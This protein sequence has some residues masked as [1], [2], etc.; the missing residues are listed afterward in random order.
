MWWLISSVL[1]LRCWSRISGKPGDDTR[2][3]LRACLHRDLSPSTCF[4]ELWLET[5]RTALDSFGSP[6]ASPP[7][8]ILAAGTAWGEWSVRISSLRCGRRW[9]QPRAML[10]LPHNNPGDWSGS[11]RCGR[12]VPAVCASICAAARRVRDVGNVRERPHHGLLLADRL[13]LPD[14]ER[15]DERFTMSAKSRRHRAQPRLS[16]TRCTTLSTR[17]NWRRRKGCCKARS[18]VKIVAILPL[19]VISA[20]ARQPRVVALFAIAVAIAMLSKV[21][22]H[23][24]EESGSPCSPSR[25]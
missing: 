7:L 10:R 16:L 5:N 19:L 20:L 8:G 17:K 9:R 12:T 14:E 11:R 23:T 21:P 1:I 3:S 6:Y 13:G 15:R 24:V 2:L 25:D 4:F 22:L 18:R